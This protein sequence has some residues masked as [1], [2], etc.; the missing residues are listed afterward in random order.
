LD[1]FG[2]HA[3]PTLGSNLPVVERPT[4]GRLPLALAMATA[5]LAQGESE[6]PNVASRDAFLGKVQ[7]KD[8]RPMVLDP[9]TGT[10]MAFEGDARPGA[11]VQV[12]INADD[13]ARTARMVGD[14]V[15]AGGS[16][17]AQ[18]LEI[19]ARHGLDPTFPPEVKAEVAELLANPGLDDPRLVDMTDKAFITIDNADSRDLDQAMFIQKRPDGGYELF[20]ALADASYY[21]KP[22]TALFKEAATRAT[23]YYLPGMA[24][25]MLP[26]ELSEGLCSLNEGVD[27][28]ALTF[29]MSLSP[30][31]TCEKTTLQR[32]KI[33]SRKKLTYDGVQK[34]HDAQDA[35]RAGSDA[36]GGKD[37]TG[38]LE[39]L[40][41][42]GEKRMRIASDKDVVRYHRN[43]VKVK[44]GKGPDARDFTLVG[45]ARNEVEK[46]NEQ[47]SLLCNVEGAKFLN[48]G[49]GA[50]L[51]SNNV[52]AIFRGHAPPSSGRVRKLDAFIDDVVEKRGLDP[53][54]WK[55]DRGGG[56]SLADYLAA[57]PTTGPE[58]RMT[59][60]ISRQAMYINNASEFGE[61]PARHHGIGADAYARF[62]SP[63]REMVGIFTHK[64]A[65]EIL[66]GKANRMP[67][68]DDI[69]LRKQI[70][71]GGNNAK[72]V[73]SKIRKEANKLAIDSL[74]APELE[75]APADRS[76]LTGTVMGL[77][78]NKIY[79]V[80]DEPP[81]EVKVYLADIEKQ[82]G[83]RFRLD[84]NEITLS[85]RDGPEAILGD[86]LALQVTGY[87][88]ATGRWQL[89]FAASDS[90]DA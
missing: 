78:K 10:Q 89:S 79:V 52:Q 1:G 77:Q 70:I 39:L 14:P 90:S 49:G 3:S 86:E 87:D 35:G 47:V 18:L 55:W 80:L 75:K 54:I 30:D 53:Q 25:P 57:L 72:G 84:E 68:S 51:A 73:Q 24:I 67:D 69:A 23:S 7:L 58:G 46:W 11:F 42:V 65:L 5:N 6:M 56:Q 34:F 41:E 45:D 71:D 61:A 4:P 22:E 83:K 33:R 82:T 28:R 50:T 12:K 21:V 9:W 44:V 43:P 59:R 17:K 76:V 36:H 29:Q 60:A 74:F 19:A 62:S 2:T 16:A 85:S 48:G 8:G 20:Y 27:R 66:D 37:F 26:K 63:M 32:T 38:T 64:E 31:G 15:A 88:E 81:I 13:A 40:Q